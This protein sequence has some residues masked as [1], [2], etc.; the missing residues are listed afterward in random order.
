[1]STQLKKKTLLLS[2][3]VLAML[4]FT[5]CNDES[6]GVEF[7]PNMYNSR[8][9]ESQSQW[10]ENTINP[11]GMNMRMPAEGTVPRSYFKTAF[12]QDDDSTVVNDLMRYDI[13][14]DSIELASRILKNPIPWS[15][16]TEKEGKVL[17]ER[18]CLHCHGENGGG[19]GKVGVVYKG[20]PVYSSAALKDITGGHI[21]HVITH[22]KGRM[23]PHGS[24]MTPEE[25]WK[26]VHYVHR[27]QLGS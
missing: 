21:F 2:V 5:S 3:T 12:L 20:V 22:G 25:R 6:T 8:A 9:L 24:Q 11:K 16:I 1:M 18:Y 13:P 26:I 7:A 19:N 4:S 23:W 15:E 14:A 17:Y 27:L 10:R